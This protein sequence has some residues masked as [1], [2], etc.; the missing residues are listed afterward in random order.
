MQGV[1]GGRASPRTI[2]MRPA[3]SQPAGGPRARP[4]AAWLRA[5]VLFWTVALFTTG[6]LAQEGRF[7]VRSAGSRLASGVYYLTARIDYRL[8]EE[9][10]DALDSGVALT[11]DV[12]IEVIRERRF[13]P[14]SLTASLQQS[15]ALSYQPLSE[16]YLLRNLNSGEQSSH[17]TLFSALSDLGRITELPMIDATLLDPGSRYQARL[18]T[19]LDQETLP[20]PLRLLAFWGSGFRLES[21]WYGWTLSD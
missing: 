6:A 15:Y 11:F 7:E 19:V 16:R 5:L 13:W 1:T 14:D 2:F 8:S 20:G 12:E 21:E 9:A 3:C 17:A 4:R 18:R 10:L